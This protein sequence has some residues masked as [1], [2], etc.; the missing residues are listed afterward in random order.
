M[1]KLPI[2]G[3]PDPQFLD[4]ESLIVWLQD[5]KLHNIPDAD[6][7]RYKAEIE[8]WLMTHEVGLPCGCRL[9]IVAL[10]ITHEESVRHLVVLPH[11]ATHNPETC[12]N[13]KLVKVIR[14]YQKAQAE[15][16]KAGEKP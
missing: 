5:V 3:L 8:K 7:W 13:R 12:R 4:L 16:F 6:L 11:T 9:R 2:P 1:T 14:K 15:A 10:D